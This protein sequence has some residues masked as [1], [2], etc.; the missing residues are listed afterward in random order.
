MRLYLPDP[1]LVVQGLVITLAVAGAA[2]W[3]GA[4]SASGFWAGLAIGGWVSLGL[5]SPGLAV[6]GTFFVLGTAATRW[7]FAEKHRHG[8]AEPGDGARGAGRVLAKGVV[9]ATL[10]V[11]GLFDGF[12]PAL[13]RAAFVGAF[14]AAAADTLGTEIGQVLGKRAWTLVPP[15]AAAPGTPGAVSFDGT[16]AGTVGAVAVAFAGSLAGIVPH[17]WALCAAAG[18][19]LGSLFEAAMAP[20]LAKAPMRDLAANL[21][22]TAAGAAAAAALA[23]PLLPGKP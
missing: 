19:V 7:R 16:L 13:V 10:A 8:L 21:V 18:G 23:L 12:H 17:S 22:T 15:R 4:V 6:V 1:S 5:G 14:A 20:V 9:G 2:R 3:F 11:A